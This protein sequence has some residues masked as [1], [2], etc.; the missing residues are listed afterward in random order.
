MEK[1]LTCVYNQEKMKQPSP[2][3][4]VLRFVE[5]VNAGDI[6]SVDSLTSDDVV[7]T[8]IQGR[9]HQEHGF[10]EG[11][12]LECPT[13][14]THVRHALQGGNGVAIVGNTTGSHVPSEI[15]KHE[16]LVWTAE[17]DSGLITKWRIYSS[18]DYANRS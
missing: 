2:R 15:E 9:V 5:C 7:F 16:T 17:V 11:Y 12:L 14:R 3:S 8:D 13:Y 18:E 6:D 1:P 10:M 4:I